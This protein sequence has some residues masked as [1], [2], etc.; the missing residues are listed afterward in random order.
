MEEYLMLVRDFG[1]DERPEANPYIPQFLAHFFM[2]KKT[3]REKI[4][5]GRRQP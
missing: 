2:K 1:Y 3:A 4:F 5:L